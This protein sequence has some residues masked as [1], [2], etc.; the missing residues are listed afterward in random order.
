[1]YAYESV[2]DLTRAQN[3]YEIAW[4]LD[5]KRMQAFLAGRA[6]QKQAEEEEEEDG[7][8]YSVP[9]FRTIPLSTRDT[10][11]LRDA[12][13]QRVPEEI[14]LL[15]LDLAECWQH[16][17]CARHHT[18][19]FPYYEVLQARPPFGRSPPMMPPYIS[20]T[21]KNRQKL[22]RIVFTTRSFEYG[23]SPLPLPEGRC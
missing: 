12:L 20:V 3:E 1:M 2:S 8:V 4:L 9:A 15:I 5:R 18:M 7:S 16:T 19:V 17:L 11:Q 13:T 21:I 6:V 23:R 14:A 10:Q 22:R